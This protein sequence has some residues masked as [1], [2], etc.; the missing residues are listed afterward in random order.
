LQCVSTSPSS[1]S[2]SSFFYY[3]YFFFFFFLLRITAKIE[4]VDQEKTKDSL[5]GGPWTRV[6]NPQSH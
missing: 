5:K 2:S 3:Y 6:I 1:S 4:R